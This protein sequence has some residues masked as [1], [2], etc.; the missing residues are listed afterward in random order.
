MVT[1]LHVRKIKDTETGGRP[2]SLE[3]PV[4][5]EMYKG[6]CAFIERLEEGG[7]PVDPVAAWH[8]KKELKQAE[9]PKIKTSEV[10]SEWKPYKDD[11]DNNINF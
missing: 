5:F 3:M 1:E 11:T 7:S 6:G 4:K 9:I 10:I 8:N 2:T